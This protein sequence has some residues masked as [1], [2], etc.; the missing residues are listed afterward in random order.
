[1]VE[2][3]LRQQGPTEP[4]SGNVDTRVWRS[5]PRRQAHAWAEIRDPAGDAVLPDTS[6][7]GLERMSKTTYSLGDVKGHP[8]HT[9]ARRASQSGKRPWQRPGLRDGTGGGWHVSTG[10]ASTGSPAAGEGVGGGSGPRYSMPQLQSSCMQARERQASSPMSGRTAASTLTLRKSTRRPLPTLRSW[11]ACTRWAS[12]PRR[13]ARSPQSG[14]GERRPSSA[15]DV[16]EDTKVRPARARSPCSRT[17]APV[18]IQERAQDARLQV[19]RGECLVLFRV[20]GAAFTTSGGSARGRVDLQVPRSWKAGTLF[21]KRR[22]P[23]TSAPPHPE[24]VRRGKKAGILQKRQA[25]L[26]YRLARSGLPE[27]SWRTFPAYYSHSGGRRKWRQRRRYRAPGSRS[28]SIH[29]WKR[30]CVCIPTCS[31]PFQVPALVTGR[32]FTKCHSRKTIPHAYSRYPPPQ[33]ESL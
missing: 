17:R 32:Q 9:A 27:N 21:T 13:P 19:D 26:G 14:N 25:G 7:K 10:R 15:G 3:P 16:P 8:P 12:Y 24:E 5:K 29:A 1:M 33:G 31:P 2:R 22:R 28:V 6:A 11:P 23:R 20:V 18:V 4:S 30:P